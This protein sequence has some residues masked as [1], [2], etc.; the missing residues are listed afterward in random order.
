MITDDT[1][2]T[3]SSPNYPNTTGHNLDCTYIIDAEIGYQ[4]ELSIQVDTE[5]CCDFVRVS[6][7]CETACTDRFS[8]SKMINHYF[9]NC[10]LKTMDFIRR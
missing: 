3:I 10:P 4:V 1:S 5:R 8:Y 9:K 6:I 7:P 2:R